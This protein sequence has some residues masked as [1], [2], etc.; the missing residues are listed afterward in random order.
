MAKFKKII[1]ALCMLLVSTIMLTGTT[2]AWFSMNDNVKATGMQ[3]TA[4]T[5]SLY[6]VISDNS[7]IDTTDGKEFAPTKTGGIG[8]SYSVYPSAKATSTQKPDGINDGEWYYASSKS[9][10]EAGAVGS[11]NFN[12]A[13]KI[14][15]AD[16]GNYHI[17]YS[18]YIGLVATS[19]VLTNGKLTISNTSAAAFTEGVKAIVTINSTE[20]VFTSTTTSFVINTFSLTPGVAVKV[21]VLLYVDGIDASVKTETT[22]EIKGALDLNFKIDTV[23]A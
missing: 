20:Y 1:P 19:E 7:T 6:L 18:F 5:N 13:T 12:G 9:A 17:T 11:T 21:D 23:G 4:K 2:F 3:V 16:K 14:E 15:D 22:T 10:T 8:D